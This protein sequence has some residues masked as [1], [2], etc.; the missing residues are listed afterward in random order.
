MQQGMSTPRK[1]V[2][3]VGGKHNVLP[4]SF[5][6]CKQDLCNWRAPG[7]PVTQLLD[8]YYIQLRWPLSSCMVEMLTNLKQFFMFVGMPLEKIFNSSH[9][10]L[11]SGSYLPDHLLELSVSVSCEGCGIGTSWAQQVNVDLVD[12]ETLRGDIQ[13]YCCQFE[14]Q[15]S[16]LISN[17]PP[18]DIGELHAWVSVGVVKSAQALRYQQHKTR[19][20]HVTTSPLCF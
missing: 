11:E 13:Y 5:L 14:R 1:Y 9:M 10:S 17:V 6:V 8:W 19:M 12:W 18:E 16:T 4:P 2:C 15:A 7:T 3:W 20:G